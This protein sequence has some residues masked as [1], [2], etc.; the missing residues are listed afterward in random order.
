M[1]SLPF[2]STLRKPARLLTLLA[3]LSLAWGLDSA[4][5]V[6]F[7]SLNVTPRGAQNLNLETGFTDL[8]QGGTATDAKGG[9]TLTAQKMQLRPNDRLNAQGA[10]LKTRQGGTLSAAQLT[11]DLKNGT[12]TASGGVTYSDARIQGLQAAGVV[13]YVSSGFV[14]ASGGVKA[15]APT[16]T[17]AALVFDPQTMQAV[18]SGPF[19]LQA[20]LGRSAGK[21]GEKLLLTFAG[22]TLT[23][24]TAKPTTD[25]LARFSAYLK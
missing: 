19:D 24:A 13:L 16:M 12:V 11:Y 22:N 15:A 1:K 6:A 9:L 17:G 4:Q 5:A 3:S 23:N 7:G 8:P 21:A 20:R 25:D 18:V 14:V 10:T 2:A